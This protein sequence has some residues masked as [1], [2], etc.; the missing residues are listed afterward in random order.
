M[1]LSNRST[2]AAL[3]VLA[4]VAVT[5]LG[6]QERAAESTATELKPTTPAIETQ[7][8]RWQREHKFEKA[9]QYFLEFNPGATAE[10]FEKLRPW[11]KPFTDVEIMAAMFSSPRQFLQWMNA[12]SEPEAVYL[13]M[14]CSTEPVMWDT[15][16]YGLTDFEK[17]MRASMRFTNPLL[18]F[19]WM[20]GMFDPQV[21]TTMIA[22]FDPN[23]YVRWAAVSANPKF[24]E[25]MFA[26]M[27]PNWYDPR[28]QWMFDP[29][30]FQPVI[31]LFGIPATP[32]S[33]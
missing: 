23:K 13:M 17:L 26:F 5:P 15:W 6:A 33:G 4:L 2:L 32:S 9:Q 22:L 8:R 16:L 1:T 7:D 30:T 10:D 11:L 3:G 18:Y 21:Y 27:D 12:I 28:L 31:N 19:N 24:Y 25:P 29:E 20:V 14:K